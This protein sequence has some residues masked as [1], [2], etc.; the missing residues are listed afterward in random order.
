M[1]SKRNAP[2]GVYRLSG[3][4]ISCFE[5]RYLSTPPVSIDPSVFSYLYTSKYLFIYIYI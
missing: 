5:K 3:F 1:F 2:K 4:E